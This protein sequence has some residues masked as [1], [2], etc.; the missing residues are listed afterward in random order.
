[1]SERSGSQAGKLSPGVR[2]ALWILGAVVAAGIV[3]LVA[4]VIVVDHTRLA[5]VVQ[6][7]VLGSTSRT[8]GREVTAGPPDVSLLPPRVTLSEVEVAGVGEEPLVFIPSIRVRVALWPLLRSLGKE[9][10]LSEVI[11]EK[12]TINLLRRAD[13]GWAHQEIADRWEGGEGDVFLDTLTV[14]DGELRVV[15]LT[16]EGEPAQVAL[17]GIDVSVSDYGPGRPLSLAVQTV[18]PEIHMELRLDALPEDFESLPFGEW[19]EI[20]AQFSLRGFSLQEIQGLL[21]AG[22][23]E[24]AR[25]GRVGLDADLHT[26]GTGEVRAYVLVGSTTVDELRLRSESARLHAEFRS[27][28]PAG[29]FDGFAAELTRLQVLGPGV[30]LGGRAQWERT[31]AAASRIQFEVEGPRL[32]LSTLLASLPEADEPRPVVD[33]ES[34][35]TEETRRRLAGITVEGTAS[36]DRVTRGEL[37]MENVEAE[38]S[39]RRGVLTFQQAQ[40]EL[41][42][43]TLNASGTTVDLGKKV[44]GWTVA[45]Q[46]EGVDLGTAFAGISGVR[47]LD[48]SL[49][50]ALQLDGEGADWET[51]RDVLDGTGDLQVADGQLQGLDLAT[52]LRQHLALAARALGRDVPEPPAAV[53][54]TQFGDFT[55]GITIDNGWIHLTRPIRFKAPQLGTGAVGGRIGLDQSL[56]LEGTVDLPPEFVASATSGRFTPEQPVQIPIRIEG[57]AQ[58]PSLRLDPADVAAA[59]APRTFRSIEKRVRERLGI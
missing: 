53:E 28:L 15:D 16:A 48:G 22:L 26:E 55:T 9:V 29:Q 54:P 46:L 33:T 52:E 44:P 4:L 51:V 2:G 25:G 6:D 35:L 34:L 10:H 13:G 19:P 31:G 38:M 41:Y 27:R 47:A 40:A 12:P 8:I 24:V 45:A 21:P 57:T 5:G 11:L 43:G 23:G 30:E 56:D 17:R 50:G 1:M 7:R 3:L 32:D 39:L 42:G 59:L 49:S 14:N 18:E 37:E 20:R 58:S 36:I